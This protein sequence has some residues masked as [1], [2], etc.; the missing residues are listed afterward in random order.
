MLGTQYDGIDA[1][2]K[3]KTYPEQ[4]A[5]L[6]QWVIDSIDCMDTYYSE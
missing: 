1:W 5:Y 3:L 4:A 6:K 2:E